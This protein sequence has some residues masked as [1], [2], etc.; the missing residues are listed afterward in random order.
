MFAAT[1]SAAHMDILVPDLFF[2]YWETEPERVP[3]PW[4]KP[5]RNLANDIRA[6]GGGE[7]GEGDVGAP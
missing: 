4:Y 3:H 5:P 2:R 7:G 6:G 1:R